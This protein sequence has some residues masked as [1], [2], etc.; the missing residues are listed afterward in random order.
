[1]RKRDFAHE[2]IKGKI[3]EQIFEMMFRESGKFSV[4]RFGYEFTEEYLAQHRLKVKFPKVI[5]NVSDAPDFLL[6]TENKS[7][8]YL[9]EVKYRSSPNEVELKEIA[10]R[11]LRRWD[12]AYIFLVA[13][14]GFYFDPA[15]TILNKDGKMSRLSKNWIPEN[16]QERY[17][18][19]AEDFLWHHP[20]H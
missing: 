9:V 13:K 20:G 12:P 6:V 8:V 4:F 3:A 17:L 14:T 5:E 19:L 7:G 10:Q 15:N 16:L 11:S 18:K 2:L 1:M